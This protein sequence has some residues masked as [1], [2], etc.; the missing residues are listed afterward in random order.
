MTTNPN[1]AS[2][3]TPYTVGANL[4]TKASD[5]AVQNQINTAFSCPSGINQ[6]AQI[7]NFII[8]DAAGAAVLQTFALPATDMLILYNTPRG[9]ITINGISRIRNFES[10]TTGILQSLTG[11]LLEMSK[12]PI[13]GNLANTHVTDSNKVSVFDITSTIP[14][15]SNKSTQITVREAHVIRDIAYQLRSQTYFLANT[16]QCNYVD[17]GCK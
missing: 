10:Y 4:C 17:L 9:T 3:A 13:T 5:P 12:D 6:T 14:T 7:S 16:G 15:A 2:D 8:Y 11:Q 1:T